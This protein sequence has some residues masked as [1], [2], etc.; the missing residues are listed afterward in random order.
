MLPSWEEINR[1]GYGVADSIKESGFKPDVI[2]ALAR[3]GVVPARII[4]DALILSDYISIKVD[5]WGVTAAKDGKARLR[6]PVNWDL[7]GKK[8]LVVDDITDTGESIALAVDVVKGM[9]PSG[10]RTATIFH[11]D[12]SKFKPDFFAKEI[13]WR[14]VIFP[15]NKHEDLV[16]LVGKIGG[17]DPIEIQK[18]FRQR[19]GVEITLEDIERAMR[20]L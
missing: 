19:H 13:P 10:L 17:D 5:H 16:S 4:C 14:W 1:L 12:H 18:E 8:V 11:I 15:W 2:I 3:G 6:R 7:S 20:S 9:N